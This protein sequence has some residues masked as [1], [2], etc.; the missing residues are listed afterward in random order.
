[1]DELLI[2]ILLFLFGCLLSNLLLLVM[3][4]VVL[5]RTILIVSFMNICDH[6]KWLLSVFT[7]EYPYCLQ[8]TADVNFE[9]QQPST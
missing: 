7:S 2:V 1:L 3:V 5:I 8:W 6:N 4:L 9:L